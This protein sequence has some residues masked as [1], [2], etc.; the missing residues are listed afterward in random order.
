[1][2]LF[3]PLLAEPFFLLLSGP[4]ASGK[5]TLAKALIEHLSE[6]QA[7]CIHLDDYLDK[8]VQPTSLFLNGIPNF[9][10]PSMTDW[11]TLLDHLEMLQQELD[12]ETPIYDFFAWEPTSS[13]PFPYKPFIIIEG[14]H[15]FQ[16]P[17]DDL[18]ALRVFLIASEETRLKRRI[19]RDKEERGYSKDLSEKIFFEIALPSE[20]LFLFPTASKADMIF[21]DLEGEEEIEEAVHEIL[22]TWRRL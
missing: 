3:S 19:Q 20:K 11:N 22:K 1:L 2:F 9:D 15:A 4:S 18:D 17:L 7:C 21:E 13:R 10:H 5:S 6:E 12:I 8:R 14:I 16:D